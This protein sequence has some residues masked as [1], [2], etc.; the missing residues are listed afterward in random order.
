LSAAADVDPRLLLE[1][2]ART[3]V[4]PAPRVVDHVRSWLRNR[5]LSI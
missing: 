4:D 5:G 1:L 2:V 3:G